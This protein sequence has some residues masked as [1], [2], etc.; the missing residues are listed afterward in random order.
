MTTPEESIQEVEKGNILINLKAEPP[1]RIASTMPGVFQVS[2]P[3]VAHSTQKMNREEVLQFLKMKN[4][5]N[6]QIIID[7]REIV[8]DTLW[9]IGLLFEEMCIDQISGVINNTSLALTM[10][11]PNKH[12]DPVNFVGNWDEA[13]GTMPTTVHSGDELVTTFNFHP[14]NL[15]TLNKEKFKADIIEVFHLI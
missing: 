8:E 7:E 2:N 4:R 11:F 10:S 6:I 5:M 9:K 12:I 14:Q 15:G 3:N 13:S 1:Y